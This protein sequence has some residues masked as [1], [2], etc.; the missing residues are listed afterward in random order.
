FDKISTE[1]KLSGDEMLE[2]LKHNQEVVAKWGENVA[3][4]ME[5]AS[6]NGYEG[7]IEWLETLGP[8][9]AAELEVLN[10]MSDDKLDDF[11]KTM[12]DGGNVATDALAKAIGDDGDDVIAS[13]GHLS[14]DTG[15]S[16]KDGISNAN[17]P[18]MGEDIVDGVVDG[19]EGQQGVIGGAMEDM[20]SMMSD[21]FKTANKIK[22][23]SG[24]YKEIGR[25]IPAGL[26]LGIAG[27][28]SDAVSAIKTVASK[29]QSSMSGLS[30]DFKT[31]GV[32]A[33]AGLGRGID[34]SKGSLF[35]KASSI[36]GG[37]AGTLRGAL[38][39]KS[40][41]R[42][43]A[44]I[45]RWIPAGIADGITKNARDVYNALDD[46][47]DGITAQDLSLDYATP[48]GIR[49]SLSSAVSGTVDVNS[50]DSMIAEAIGSLERRL[51]DL[52]VVMDGE[53]VGR[54][55]RPHINDQDA[56]EAM[57]RRYFD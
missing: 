12:S 48:E 13:V 53:R 25:E 18:G 22:S 34:A 7:F 15:E 47:S 3:E 30:G 23:P 40:P 17:F 43:M 56:V 44:E 50:R 35:A 52:E 33:M 42:V 9:S 10:N 24:L 26:A 36:A 57:T 38:Q 14:D 1:S 16:M 49:T 46:I 5:K 29:M 41:S 6:E 45:G 4:L 19:V 11:M 27:K 8:D 51:G 20:A 54:I 55:I 31:I 37:I 39:I 32:N 2:N 21:T 28:Q